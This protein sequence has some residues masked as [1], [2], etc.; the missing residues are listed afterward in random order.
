MK[1]M[2]PALLPTKKGWRSLA[3]LYRQ[4]MRI[5]ECN[6]QSVSAFVES[7]REELRLP[8][9]YSYPKKSH[10]YSYLSGSR[11]PD[12]HFL[13]VSFAAG[14]FPGKS[15]EEI[16]AIACGQSWERASKQRAA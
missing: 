7:H 6:A 10:I 3:L 14:L 15:R 1:K 5:Q 13:R 4:G 8:D 16:E 2:E 12:L 9:D 11:V